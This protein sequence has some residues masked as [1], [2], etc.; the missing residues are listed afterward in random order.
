MK[1]VAD[2]NIPSIER[3]F[4]AY[5]DEIV[6]L[7]GRTITAEDVS[8]ADA[9]IVRSV[10]RVSHALLEDSKVSFVGTCTIGTDH[11]DISA[12]ESLGI[13]W[14]SAP[15]CNAHSVADYVIAA[16]A[17]IDRP[18]KYQR[19]AVIGAGNVGSRVI[20]R[21]S[22]LGAEVRVYDPFLAPPLVTD[23]ALK[24]LFEWAEIICLHAPLTKSGQ[25]PTVGMIDRQMVS[26]CQAGTMILSAGRGAVL[27]DD[28]VSSRSDID[29]VLDVWEDEPCVSTNSVSRARIATP[30]IAGYA[31]EGKLR[32]TWMIFNAWAKQSNLPEIEWSSVSGHKL[33]RPTESAEWQDQILAVYDI[34]RDDALF[35]AALRGDAAQNGL[36]FDQLRKSYPGRH[37]FDQYMW[38]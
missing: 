9:L 4:G 17:A 18:V 30:H 12:I 35:R 23:T 33:Q 36:A 11:L 27:T 5:F 6:R 10:T 38:S 14:S 3:L 37:E 31:N 2:E 15:G 19:V 24:P 26:Y 8:D 32:G 28:A 25:H 21:F 29:W 20:Q 1:L 16:C 7:P 22:K 13:S 34:W